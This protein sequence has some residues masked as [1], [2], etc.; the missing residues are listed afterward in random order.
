[1]VLPNKA[2]EELICVTFNEVVLL[3]QGGESRFLFS[4][5]DVFSSQEEMELLPLPS[6]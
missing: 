3:N 6:L 1:M 4:L 2:S 5:T